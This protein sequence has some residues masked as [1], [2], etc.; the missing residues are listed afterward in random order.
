MKKRLLVRGPVLSQSGYGEQARFALQ[1]IRTREDLF[2]IYIIPTGWGHT[3]WVAKNSEERQWIDNHILRAARLVEEGKQNNVPPTSLFDISL[4]ITIPNEWENLAPVNVGYTAGIET[5]KVSPM[6]L[7]KSN[8]MDR[9]IVVS[10]HAKE[11]YDASLYTHPNPNN[12]QDILTLKCNTP[13]GVANYC[14]R[15]D[16]PV[17]LDLE[18]DYDFNFL[19][20]AQMGPRKNLGN[21]IKWFM[22]ENFDKEVGLIVKSSIKNNCRTDREYSES[23]LRQ[24]MT[25]Y[26]N[27]KCK[28]YLLHGDMSPQE[29]AGLYA[30]PKIKSIVSTTHGEGFG[31]PLFE[32]ACHGLPVIAPGWSGQCDFLYMPDSRRKN[33]SKTRPMFA[34]VEYDLEFVQPEAVW[35]HII[36]ADSQ[37][38]YPREA[39]FKRRLREVYTKYSQFEK[40]A[41]KLQ[42]WILEEFTPEK[43]YGDFLKHLL[44]D[45]E[46]RLLNAHIDTEDLPKISLITSVFDAS[47]HIEQLMEDVTRQTIFEEK[48]EWIILNVN[49]KGNNREEEIIL[50]YAEKYPN[51]IVYKRLPTDPGVY[52]VWNEAIKMSTGEFVTNINCDDRR[53]PNGLEIQAKYLTICPDIDLVYN[54][55]YIS[56]QSNTRWEDLKPGSERY[57]FEPFSKEAM[58]RGNQ[59]HNNPMWRK[60]LHDKYGFFEA[61]YRSAGDW[62]FFLRCTMSGAKFKKINDILGVYYFNPRGISTNIENTEWKEKEEKEIF[63]KYKT[64]FENQ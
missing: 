12:P 23:S 18:L 16:D 38:C 42:K 64:I 59:P 6:W 46:Y 34:T 14:T 53:S 57:H 35:E 43:K 8:H 48:C 13:I 54:D 9:I 17:D 20:M 58:L 31:L 55:S 29:I 37:W 36:Q 5:N 52:G 19:C 2:D 47:E 41:K 45:E 25:N 51:N 33:S 4:Q 61:K 40:N 44:G 7:E 24:L 49:P 27:H 21:T 3:G 26:K 63:T 22:E 50:K 10:N 1:A 62:E 28:I 32:A 39:S 60:N 11:V 56:R 30:H 15:K